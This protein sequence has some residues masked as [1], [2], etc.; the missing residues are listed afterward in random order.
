MNIILVEK[1]DFVNES[2]AVRIAGRR[3]THIK[4]VLSAKVGDLLKCGELGGK[5]GTGEIIYI[6]KSHVELKVSLT[7]DPP[8]ALPVNVV[9]ALPRPKVIKRLLQNITT[10]G[11]KK[12]FL[13]NANLVEKSYWQSP[14]L[15][16]SEIKKQLI[17]GLEQAR[18]TILPEV[19][20]CR[21]FKI[22]V[23]DKLPGIIKG[24]KAILAHPGSTDPCP[25]LKNKPTTIAIGPEG[26]F[27]TYEIEKL[28][29]IGFTEISLG[30]R[31]LKTE[32]A[33]IALLSKF[34][35]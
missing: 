15:S 25:I 13:I 34:E 7:E 30:K 16:E 9:V 22:F 28:I 32:T 12:I 17:L 3:F 21:S 1:K 31:I 6:D 8:R 24:K 27:I 4:E 23:E 20:L 35:S 26:G 5:M 18:D 33:L 14:A 29:S 10:L 19:T 11:V 2:N